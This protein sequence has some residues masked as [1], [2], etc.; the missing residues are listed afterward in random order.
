[1]YCEGEGVL[2]DYK[3]AAY[4]IKKTHENGNPDAEG[5][6]NEYELWKYDN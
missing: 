2:K 1:M 6:W 5:I 4:W 3:K